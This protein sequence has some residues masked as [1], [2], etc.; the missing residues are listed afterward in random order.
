MRATLVVI[1][2]RLCIFI[3]ILSLSITTILLD[4]SKLDARSV[5]DSGGPRPRALG[6]AHAIEAGPGVRLGD[7]DSGRRGRD[8]M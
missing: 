6:L 5:T 7:G 1:D 2:S 3:V 4:V 8:E